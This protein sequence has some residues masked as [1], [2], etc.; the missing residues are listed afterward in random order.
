MVV[1]KEV[2]WFLFIREQKFSSLDIGLSNTTSRRALFTF[3][4]AQVMRFEIVRNS[5][6]E[7]CLV[8]NKKFVL[9]LN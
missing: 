4:P 3:E 7:Q 1:P 8:F 9:N 6:P 2:Y 5:S